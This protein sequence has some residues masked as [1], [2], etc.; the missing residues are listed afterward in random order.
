MLPSVGKAGL[1]LG[2]ALYCAV[3]L[4]FWK[5][6][7][8]LFYLIFRRQSEDMDDP[9]FAFHVAVS[10]LSFV[11]SPFFFSLARPE[12]PHIQ[13][14]EA[15]YRDRRITSCKPSRCAHQ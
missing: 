3:Q 7:F 2:R 4:I 13:Y 8:D 5:N 11:A 6:M 9:E 15:R 10:S 1:G 14:P 12:M